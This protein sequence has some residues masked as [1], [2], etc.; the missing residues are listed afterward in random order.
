LLSRALL[1]D[2]SRPVEHRRGTDF[3]TVRPVC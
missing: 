2:P 3:G 1:I